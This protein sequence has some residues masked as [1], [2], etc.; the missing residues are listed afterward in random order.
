MIYTWTGDK[1]KTSL[2]TGEWVFKFD[3][4]IEALGQIDELN[5]ELGV[6]IEHCKQS[7]IEVDKIKQ[8]KE[9]QCWLFEIGS[10]IAT[11]WDSEKANAK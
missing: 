8:L 5:A 1:G 9:I 7:K 10:H 6:A 2:Y 11:P 4:T 3:P